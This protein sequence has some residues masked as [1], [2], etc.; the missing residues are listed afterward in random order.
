MKQ[1]YLKHPQ[2]P[3]YFWLALGFSLL[4]TAV[5]L[6]IIY[7]YSSGMPYRDD[8]DAIFGFL[9]V[10]P[11]LHFPDNLLFLFSQNNEHRIFLDHVISLLMVSAT[12][13]F[14]FFWMIW[15]GNIGWLLVIY[16]LWKFAKENQVNFVEFS[17]ILIGA[18][19]LS[20]YELMTMA[21]A[22][23]QHYFQVFFCV[24]AVWCLVSGRL[25]LTLT[26]FICAI[27]TAGG[28]I[29]LVPIIFLYYLSKKEWRNLIASMIVVAVVFI[30]YFPLLGYV[31]PATHPNVLLALRSPIYLLIYSF[32]FLGGIGNTYKVAIALGFVFTVIFIKKWRF[33]YA[34]YPFLF[35][36][37]IYLFATAMTNAITRGAIGIRTG[38]GS[39]YT[40]YS[41]LFTAIVY[42]SCLFHASSEKLRARVAYAGFFLSLVIFVYWYQHGQEN[43]A[44]RYDVLESGVLEHPSQEY[45][46]TMLQRAMELGYYQPTRTPHL[47]ISTK[48]D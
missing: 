17:P 29:C 7:R 34:N 41:L 35:W 38:Q 6:Y 19:C 24:L 2:K 22:G 3:L 11:S 43:I 12:G 46:R 14:N 13:K 33:L 8:Y 32:G 15:I 23:V 48:A 16:M 20:H 9:N 39:R 47:S 42:F 26:F 28:G 18:M 40:T 45:A 30:I 5:H 44:A 25:W 4:A 36:L 27:F 37:A 10:Y 21:M 1:I 31:E